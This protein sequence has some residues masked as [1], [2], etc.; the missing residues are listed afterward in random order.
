[1]LSRIRSREGQ[2]V[3]AHPLELHIS[4]AGRIPAGQGLF[5]VTVVQVMLNISQLKAQEQPLLMCSLFLGSLS[6]RRFCRAC[7]EAS[8]QTQH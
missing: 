3:E 2:E 8:M 5:D 7:G 6:R 1:M 4:Y